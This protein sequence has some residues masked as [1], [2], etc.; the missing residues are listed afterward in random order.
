MSANV[1]AVT[2]SEYVRA[3]IG[4]DQQVQAAKKAGVNQTTMSRWLNGGQAG[5][6]ENIAGFARGYSRPVLEAFLAA[7]FL[8][9]EEASARVT[10]TR[11]EQPDDD[12]L[13]ALLTERLRRD[14]EDG[15]D[16]A[17]QSASNTDAAGP[18]EFGL[19]ARKRPKPKG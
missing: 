6:A 4:S 16:S 14:R 12:T 18:D 8:T 3:T 19:A 13:I 1:P 7:G 17:E 2:W 15:G 10:I 5:A 11:Y 9:P